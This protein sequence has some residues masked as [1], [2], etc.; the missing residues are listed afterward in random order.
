MKNLPESDSMPKRGFLDIRKDNLPAGPASK[1]YARIC[2]TLLRTGILSATLQEN[3][4]IF[5]FLCQ[6]KV[7]G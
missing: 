5:L 6:R 7:N 2:P 4:I 3:F 1:S